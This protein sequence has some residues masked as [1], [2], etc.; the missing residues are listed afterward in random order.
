MAIFFPYSSFYSYFKI[1]SRVYFLHFIV[2]FAVNIFPRLEKFHSV[3]L[4]NPI[5][6]TSLDFPDSCHPS[7]QEIPTEHLLIIVQ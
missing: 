6:E 1:F 2:T 3:N 7:I 4:L 5:F